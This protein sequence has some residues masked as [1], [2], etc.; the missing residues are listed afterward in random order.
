[1]SEETFVEE[2]E[3]LKLECNFDIGCSKENACW[4]VVHN[5]SY[6]FIKDLDK[7]DQISKTIKDEI[8]KEDFKIL[9]SHPLDNNYKLNIKTINLLKIIEKL[10]LVKNIHFE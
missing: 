8:K 5:C 9:D 10:N 3:S 2:N 7:I 6:E 4:N 1:M